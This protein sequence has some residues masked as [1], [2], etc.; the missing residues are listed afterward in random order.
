MFGSMHSTPDGRI[1]LRFERTFAHPPQ[2]VWRAIT[3]PACFTQWYPFA[4]GERDQRVG[5]RIGFDD[6]EGTTYDGTI[7]QFDPSRIF[8]FR[9]GDN[10]LQCEVRPDGGRSLLVFTHTFDDKSM[11]TNIATGWHRCL[12]ALGMLVDD[13]PVEWPDNTDDLHKTYA[14]RLA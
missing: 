5:G 3:E 2:Q 8:A 1:A 6:G 10:L 7:T 11:A 12:D 14:E 4:A 13:R 9:E